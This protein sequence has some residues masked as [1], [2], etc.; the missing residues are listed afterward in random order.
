MTD[1]SLKIKREPEKFPES[2]STISATLKEAHESPSSQKEKKPRKSAPKN[3]TEFYKRAREQQEEKDRARK[4]PRKSTS[5]N[6]QSPAAVGGAI[7][8]SLNRHDFISAYRAASEG[9]EAPVI[10]AKTV[11]GQEDAFKKFLAENPKMD[12]RKCETDLTKLKKLRK[13]FGARKFAVS[14]GLWLLK[15]MLTSM[16]P[17]FANS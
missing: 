9:V 6:A 13:T 4:K 12:I 8:Q 14:D 3:P 11:K 2:T 1:T 16:A 15:G 5:Y 7:L 17:L 10:T